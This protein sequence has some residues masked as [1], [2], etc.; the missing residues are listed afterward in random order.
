MANQVATEFQVLVY[1][2]GVSTTVSVDLLQSPVFS[3][4][5]A[6][7]INEFSLNHKLPSSIVM[8]GF[9]TASLSGNTVT[10]TFASAPT[11]ETT[12]T[13]YFLFS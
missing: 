1:G 4:N 11:G 12:V 7:F 8:L 5:S 2:D 6:V 3:E 9:T 13:G 10:F